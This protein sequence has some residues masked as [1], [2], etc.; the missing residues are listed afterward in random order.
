MTSSHS[1]YG[2]IGHPLGHSFSQ[3]YFTEK[4][5]QQAIDACYL[6]FDIPSIDELP[7]ILASTSD[8]RGFNVTI[9]YK[10]AVIPFLSDISEEA[11]SIGAVNVVKVIREDDR[12]SL[13]GFNTDIIGFRESLRKYLKPSNTK[14]LILGTGGASKAV[15]AGLRQ[16]AIEPVFVSRRPGPGMLSY[17]DL[18]A[19]VIDEHKVIV[20]ATPLGTFPNIENAPDMPYDLLTP[21]HICFDLVYN[22]EVTLFLRKALDKKATAVNG[23]EML[24]I[25]AEEAWKIWTEK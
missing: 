23:L 4:F 18:N 1:T 11:A 9:P 8:L 22:P 12:I 10:Q 2:L 5:S 14:A 13:H 15:A 3:R 7:E 16:L 21:E 6:N 20:N 24:H 25:Q 17:S 19:Q